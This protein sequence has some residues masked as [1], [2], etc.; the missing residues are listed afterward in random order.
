MKT[1]LLTLAL[2]SIRSLSAQTLAC[3]ATDAGFN[4]TLYEASNQNIDVQYSGTFDSFGPVPDAINPLLMFPS[5]GVTPLYIDFAINQAVGLSVLQPGTTLQL[6]V[7]F[8]SVGQ[9]HPVTT[10]C[11]VYVTAPSAAKPSIQ[12]V[13]NGASLQPVLSP[14][15]LV[16][17]FGSNLSGAAQS[18]TYGPTGMYPTTAAGFATN[19]VTFNGFPAPLLYTSPNQINAIVPFALAGQ[20]SVQIVV[21]RG[22]L[23]STTLA[24]PLQDTSPGIFTATQTGSGQGAILQQTSSAS[25]PTYNSSTNPAP[26]GAALEIFATGAGVWTPAAQLDVSLGAQAFTTQPVSVTIGGQPAKVAYAGTIG[27]QSAWS[28]LQVNVTVPSGLGSG[29]QPIVLK[30]GANDSS[31]QNV[32]VWIQ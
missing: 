19:Q 2:V 17:I 15:E 4:T 30:I 28:I 24:V 8:T 32:T 29:P 16:T 18:L 26:A 27:G 5:S 21:T 10:P 22:Q 9:L 23:F 12:S 1:L 31:Q 13:V 14:G 25:P 3:G 20:K 11:Q 7:V 6:S